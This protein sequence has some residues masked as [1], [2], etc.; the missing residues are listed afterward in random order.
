MNRQSPLFVVTFMAGLCMV[1]G[2]GVALVHYA[3][4]DRLAA[5]D[6]LNHNRVVCAAFNLPVDGRTPADYVRAMAQSL[7]TATVVT[8]AGRRRLVYRQRDDDDRLIGFTFSGMGFWDRIDGF[9]TLSAD[10]TAIRRLRFFEHKETPGLGA[11][12]EEPVF[13]EAFEDL[14]IDWDAPLARRVIIGPASDPRLKNRVDAVTGATQTSS[15]LMIFLN[16]EL[17]RI[18]AI[19]LRRLDFKPATGQES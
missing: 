18:R 7:E 13:L 10:L 5:N 12:I 8:D 6:R 17:E 14:S 16:A 19:D 11:R 15:A 3:T 1:F 9:V 4:R 2:S